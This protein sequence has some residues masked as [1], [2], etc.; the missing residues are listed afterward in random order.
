MSYGS[1]KPVTGRS[2]VRFHDDFSLPHTSTGLVLTVV[3]R[4]QD[5]YTQVSYRACATKH[6]PHPS[7]AASLRLMELKT[8]GV[9]RMYVPGGWTQKRDMSTFL[10]REEMESLPSHWHTAKPTNNVC[11]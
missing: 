3:R 1:D 10:L 11:T 9:R 4:D 6:I 8:K 7:S 2:S 5:L